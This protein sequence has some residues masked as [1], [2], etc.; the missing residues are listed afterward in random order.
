MK[1]RY[2]RKKER[3]AILKLGNIKTFDIKQTIS[4]IASVFID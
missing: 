1:Q 4:L 3:G 2:V